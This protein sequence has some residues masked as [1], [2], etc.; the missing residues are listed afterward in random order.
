[1]CWNGY[2]GIDGGVGGIA[3]WEGAILLQFWQ[4]VLVAWISAVIPG[5]NIDASAL[6]VIIDVP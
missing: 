3:A 1:M 6:A 4:L 2:V 5:Q